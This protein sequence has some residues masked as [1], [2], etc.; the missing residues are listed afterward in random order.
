MSHSLQAAP[1]DIYN[2]VGQEGFMLE[3][4]PR[5][6]ILHGSTEDRMAGSNLYKLHKHK[7]RMIATGSRFGLN[8][9]TLLKSQELIAGGVIK[10]LSS[11]LRQGGQGSFNLVSTGEHQRASVSIMVLLTCLG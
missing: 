9:K 3:N 4:I 1:L 11:T 8:D 7:K 10:S 5:A 2:P 6:L